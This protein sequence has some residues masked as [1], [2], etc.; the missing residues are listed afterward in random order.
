[1]SLVRELCCKGLSNEPQKSGEREVTE[2]EMEEGASRSTPDSC[3]QLRDFPGRGRGRLEPLREEVMSQEK[4]SMR[5]KQGE[6]RRKWGVFKHG[7]EK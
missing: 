6:G 1:M 4:Q 3:V 5:K 2:H 7:Q